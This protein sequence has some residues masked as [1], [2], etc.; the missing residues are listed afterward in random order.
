MHV[1]TY[2]QLAL[3]IKKSQVFLFFLT[4]HLIYNFYF[5]VA[6]VVFAFRLSKWLCEAPHPPNSDMVGFL[7]SQTELI[8]WFITCTHL[9][10]KQLIRIKPLLISV[11][12][13]YR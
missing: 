8:G 5:T 9:V 6:T 4:P 7:T 3:V 11:G 10:F 1:I 2:N 12:N 13:V